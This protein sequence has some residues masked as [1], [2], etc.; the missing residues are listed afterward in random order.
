MRI[1]DVFDDLLMKILLFLPANEAVKCYTSIPAFV[2][3][4]G[5]AFSFWKFLAK[6][7]IE[8]IHR[9]QYFESVC[10]R[11]GCITEKCGLVILRKFH[12]HKKCFRLGCMKLFSEAQN[13]ETSCFYHT[14]KMNSATKLLS[15]CRGAGFDSIGCKQGCHDGKVFEAIVLREGRPR[16]SCTSKKEYINSKEEV[17]ST[18][19]RLPKIKLAAESTEVDQPP[20]R[21]RGSRDDLLPQITNILVKDETRLHD[22]L[23][24][25]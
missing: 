25:A 18:I 10:S 9:N 3:N 8:L 12:M 11:M 5:Q 15:C 2:R 21:R 17:E 14:G 16:I 4:L 6:R 1:T 7:E 22:S 23:Q 20:I 24:Q 19:L 13:K